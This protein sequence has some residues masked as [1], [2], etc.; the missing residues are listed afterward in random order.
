MTCRRLVIALLFCGATAR[1]TPRRYG[2]FIGNNHGDP[3]ETALLYA[4]EEAARMA[5]IF[6]RLGGATP[7]G[8]VLLT[9]DSADHV[10]SGIIAVNERIRRDIRD[11]NT[12][13]LFLY[14]SGHADADRLHLARSSLA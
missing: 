2:I 12:V 14:Y 11:G 13:L 9:G 4:E 6:R 5:D 7:D 8:V 10:R 3:S 1:A